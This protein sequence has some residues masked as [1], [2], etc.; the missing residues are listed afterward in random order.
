MHELFRDMLVWLAGFSLASIALI[1]GARFA[2]RRVRQKLQ[3]KLKGIE[4]RYQTGSAALQMPPEWTLQPLRIPASLQGVATARTFLCLTILVA[5][6]AW[7]ILSPAG[8]SPIPLLLSLSVSGLLFWMLGQWL[9][10]EHVTQIPPVCR[11]LIWI[12]EWGALRVASGTSDMGLALR[13]SARQ[14]PDLSPDF[15]AWWE[16]CLSVRQDR[17][18]LKTVVSRAGPSLAPRLEAVLAGESANA[19]QAL[20]QL[21]DQIENWYCGEVI[22]RTRKLDAWVKYPLALCLIPALNLALFGPAITHLFYRVGNSRLQLQMAPA[23]PLSDAPAPSGKEK[24]L[25]PEPDP[26]ATASETTP[27]QSEISPARNQ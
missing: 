24:P 18:R 27:A 25:I 21:A 4:Q 20:R 15:A 11:H 3:E 17:E 19:A 8:L 12:L 26:G 22:Q 6:G 7:S 2:L 23:Q 1:G 5:G 16:E 9:Q 13:A 14:I 10:A